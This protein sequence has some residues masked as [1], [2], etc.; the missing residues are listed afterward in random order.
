MLAASRAW[1]AAN[2]ER[3]RSHNR[4]SAH[5]AAERRRIVEQ[6]KESGRAWYAEHR[7]AERMR[8]RRFRLE[9]PEKVHE[10]RARFQERHPERAAEQ[11]R[12][13]SE[14]WHDKNA[15]AIR[16]EQR[17]AAHQRRASDPDAYRRWYQANLEQQRARGREASRLRSRLK[18]LGLPTRRVRH[19]YS[20][21]RR[22]NDR[23]SA[24]FFSRRRSA[25]EMHRLRREGES[26][27]R[28]PTR[29][30]LA[31]LEAR[32]RVMSREE[33]AA[34]GTHLQERLRAAKA[35]DLARAFFPEVAGRLYHARQDRLRCEIQLDSIARR[36]RGR[37][38][39]DVESELRR[40]VKQEASELA[41]TLAQRSADE[42]QM[43]RLIDH[44][45][46]TSRRSS[47]S[48]LAPAGVVKHVSPADS[49][50]HRRGE[51]AFEI[52]DLP[53]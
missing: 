8:A 19:T 45:L 51:S 15:E 34:A 2:P 48:V 18:N 46:P 21:E 33:L 49:Q 28:R 43:K 9:H 23:A 38:P 7:E 27:F 31:V 26:V 22:A 14:R 5:K 3:A 41:L 50:A 24:E 1:K 13:A 6:R 47:R 42:D 10:Y 39:Y 17:I 32:R 40:R 37:E 25:A 16:E 35:R 12:R 11:A 44:R 4:R 36:V 20:N 52:R 29:A 30:Q 53:N